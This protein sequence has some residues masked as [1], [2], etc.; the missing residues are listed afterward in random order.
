MVGATVNINPLP[1]NSKHWNDKDKWLERSKYVELI[2]ENK[3]ALIQRYLQRVKDGLAKFDPNGEN[4]K[5]R[6]EANYGI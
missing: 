2:E 5:R 3:H 4:A 6:I 1:P